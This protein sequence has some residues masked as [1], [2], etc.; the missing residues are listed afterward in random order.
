MKR[1]NEWSKQIGRDM[2]KSKEQK[3][4]DLAW[5]TYRKWGISGT[6]NRAVKEFQ[7]MVRL[8]SA[9][10]NG[11]VVCVTCGFENNW[12]NSDNKMNAGHFVG[13]RSNSIVFIEDNVHPQCVVCNCHHSGRL[14]V[15]ES[16]MVERYGQERVTE[17]KMLRNQ[18]VKLDAET[19]N[20]MRLEYHERVKTAEKR[21]NQLGE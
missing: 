2:A 12:R 14:D 3:A 16:W 18:T 19:L 20:D 5:R 10:E 8:E 9:D 13:G 11:Q 15:Y 21:L 17:I 4:D 1:T 7:R 6:K